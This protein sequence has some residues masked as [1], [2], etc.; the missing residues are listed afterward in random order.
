MKSS[1]LHSPP[2]VC[3]TCT[4]HACTWISKCIEIS[5][6]MLRSSDYIFKTPHFSLFRR[7]HLR[8]KTFPTSSYSITFRDQMTSSLA[9]AELSRPSVKLKQ[10]WDKLDP[11]SIRRNVF[12]TANDFL[13]FERKDL[14]ESLPSIFELIHHELYKIT[15]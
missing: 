14:S 3:V 5:N 2:Y 15:T 11:S 8:L 7:R 10:A 9:N 12:A 13:S 6:P 4:M 1:F